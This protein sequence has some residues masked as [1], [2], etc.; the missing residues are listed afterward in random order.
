MFKEKKTINNTTTMLYLHGFLEECFIRDLTLE[1]DILDSLSF[2]GEMIVVSCLLGSIL[3]GSYFKYAVYQHMYDKR[4]EIKP[5][6]LLILIQ[7]L[8]DH[9]DC[10]WMALTY[11]I[12]LVFNITFS[13]YF[14]E[15][16]CY[17]TLYVAIFGMSHRTIAGLGISIFRLFYIKRPHTMRDSLFRMKLMITVEI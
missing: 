16:G 9:L 5:V 3:A 12:G 15:P 8:I 13:D 14:G 6:D 1:E 10:M 17:V 11:T 4:K 2:E 7:A